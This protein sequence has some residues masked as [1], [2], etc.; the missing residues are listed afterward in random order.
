[1]DAKPKLLAVVRD[2]MRA[3]HFSYRTEQAYVG[4]IRRFILYHGKR[5]PREMGSAEVESF[6]TISLSSAA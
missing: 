5:H 1:M 4:W 6:L 3:R 2:K